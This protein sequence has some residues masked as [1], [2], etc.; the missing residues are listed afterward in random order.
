MN[1]LKRFL[2]ALMPLLAAVSVRADGIFPM[3]TL[4]AYSPDCQMANVCLPIPAADFSNY[5]VFHNGSP[6]AAGVSGC[7]FDTSITYSYNTLFGL[8]NMGPYHLDGWSV[9]GQ[10]H[11]VMFMNIVELVGMLNVW[12]PFGFW[13]HDASTLTIK[14][15]APGSDYSDMEVTVMA[16]ST[17]SIIGLNLGLLPQGSEM[18][19][20]VGMNSLIAI[21]FASNSKDTLLVMVECLVLP[22]PVY[23]YDTI[24]AD[25]LPYSICF[26]NTNLFGAPVSIENICPD[27]SGTFV[28][29]FVDTTNFCVKYSGNRCGGTEQACIVVC[30]NIGICDTTYL[31]ITVDGSMCHA[32]SRKVVDTLL[33][34]FADTF[35]LD[36]G[37]VPGNVVSIEN[38]C[39][40]ESGESV[41]FDF[42]P[43]TNCIIYTGFAPGLDQACFLITDDYGNTDTTTICVYVRLPESGTIIDTIA[44]NTSETYCFDTTELAGNIV[45]ITNFCPDLSGTE[46]DFTP[47]NVSLC[48]FAEGIAI[49]TDTACIVICD[50]YGVCDTTYA[51]ITVV[52]D[53]GPCANSL[54]PNAVDDAAA[55]PLNTPVNIDILAN[56]TLGNCLPVELIILYPNTGGI[57][58]N[59]G[60]TVLNPN[61]SVDYIPNQDF[62]GLDTFQYVLC[63]PVGCDTATVVVDVCGNDFEIVIY[64][65]FSPNGDGVNDVFKIKNI[66]K[67]SNTVE[68]YNR[69]GLMVFQETDY[70]NTWLGTYKSAD[71]PD[72]TYFYRID[73][74][75]DGRKFNGFLQLQR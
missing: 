17:Q 21:D 9:N 47:N 61:Q 71:L 43:V 42:D 64:N 34:N 5:L 51:Y 28:D 45:S 15:G 31:V 38:I 54:P 22:P 2:I 10:E 12:D 75:K 49:G 3:D 69:W 14:G 27:D 30:D 6:F 67:F 18:Q 62:C 11:E 41:D 60:L 39:P 55:T 35:C 74:K 65:G 53:S 63:N 26:N 37:N 29:F 24:P 8:G 58:P 66:G 57:G 59:H 7:N 44:L 20:P 33:I 40:D 23:F 13:S 68:V 25:S 50:D 52:P 32:D 4:H 1:K 70:D 72:G 19:L 36:L 56:D 46:V 73:L 16:N 48:L